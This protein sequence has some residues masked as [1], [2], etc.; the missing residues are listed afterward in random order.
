MS[1]SALSYT[2][3]DLW[4]VFLQLE[5]YRRNIFTSE[6]RSFKLRK[7]GRGSKNCKLFDISQLLCCKVFWNTSRL[8]SIIFWVTKKCLTVRLEVCHHL[9]E[10]SFFCVQKHQII[11]AEGKKNIFSIVFF[12]LQDSLVF[13]CIFHHFFFFFS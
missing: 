13:Q 2:L 6:V 3:F 9:H 5:H 11:E 12:I 1:C 4:F 8:Y 7:E 10:K